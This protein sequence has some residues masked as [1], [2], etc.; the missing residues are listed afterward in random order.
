MLSWR[1]SLNSLHF[2]PSTFSFLPWPKRLQSVCFALLVTAP[3][4]SKFLIVSQEAMSTS[5]RPWLHKSWALRLL[6]LSSSDVILEGAQSPPFQHMKKTHIL[7]LAIVP[8][9]LLVFATIR[10]SCANPSYASYFTET[11]QAQKWTLSQVIGW[12]IL[13]PKNNQIA[14][15]RSWAISLMKSSE[16]C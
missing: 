7:L 13:H 8:F 4:C 14:T 10:D 3:K 15:M 11:C 2:P 5:S 9:T 1:L 16:K 12:T 6:R